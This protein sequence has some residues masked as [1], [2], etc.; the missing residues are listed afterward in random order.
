MRF[1]S[2]R[3]KINIAIFTTCIGI[4]LLFGAILY[5]FERNRRE[6]RIDKIKILLSAVF[7]QR[8]EELANE[9][10]AG[11]KLAL[12]RSL[13]EIRK[14][15]GVA[16]LSV[17]GPD[18][19]LTL[20]TDGRFSRPL[21]DEE[22][23]A[24]ERG[25]F[26]HKER[27]RDYSY[28]EYTTPV[29][30]IGERV[31]YLKI[32]F[33]LSEMEEETLLTIVIFFTLLVSTLL[34]V[35]GILNL[36]LSRSVIRPVSVLRDA[37][38]EVR[39]GGLGATVQLASRDEVGEMA[40]AFNEMSAK[41]E[42]QHLEIEKAILAKDAYALEL[43]KTNRN[44]EDLNTRLEDIVGE[45]TAELRES[46]ERLQ[47]EINERKRADREKRNLEERLARSQKMEALG[48]LAGG[49]A[50]DLNNVLSG[51]VSYPDLLLMEL[52]RDSPLRKP[53]LTIRESGQKAAAI[54]QDLLTLA[55]RGVITREVLNLNDIVTEYLKSPEHEKLRFYHG[56]VGFETDLDPGLLNV[57]GSAVH[58]KKCVM[59]LIS[60]AAEAQPNGGK[61]LV[62]TCNRYVDKPVR[63]Y[64][65]VQEGDYVLLSVRDKGS[66]IA[67]HDLKRIFEPFYT[68]K[69]MG[70]SGTG[71]G[72]SVVWGTV[73]DH[74]GYIDLESV[75]GKGTT[76]ELYFPVT[77][78]EIPAP[79]RSIPPERYMGRGESILVVDDIRE[80]REIASRILEK[81]GYVVS[82]AASGHEALAWLEN[83]PADLIVLDMIMEPGIDGLDAYRRI[84]S[85]HPGQRA[86]IASGFAETE[87]VKE[88]Q[89]LGAG[90]YLKK[91]YTLEKLGLAV[92]E[93]LDRQPPKRPVLRQG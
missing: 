23:S 39:G 73:Q 32:Y 61:I 35:A 88:A 27:G 62:S 15:N 3:F 53:I 5:P 74:E 59:N 92:R 68:K 31:G 52:P 2:L 69:V 26:L 10:F 89:K 47:Q 64:D 48:L 81:L 56:S 79:E 13:Q 4:A 40:E 55:R 87:R 1:H 91:P 49:V 75:E 82:S 14:V 83:N 84:A 72:M 25:P 41:L 78:E 43:E 20:S 66:G 17:Y 8:R 46:N 12:A 58:L 38:S 16:A 9:I 51:T 76:F 24:A 30:V 37:I 93:E 18:G 7:Q 80:Q 42:E 71:L 50:H 33:D 22:K 57:R 60:N 28:A 36:L 44:L 19:G 67:S 65:H 85:L 70:R 77:R 6:A 45:R 54:V 11:Q 29:E 21:S 34:I 63:G 90:Q 86:I